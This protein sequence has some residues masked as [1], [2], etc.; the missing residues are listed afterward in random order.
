MALACTAV[1]TAQE[2]DVEQAAVELMQ[3]ARE[4]IDRGLRFLVERQREDGTFVSRNMGSNPAVVALGG[5]A[6]LASGSS[7]GRGPYGENI[8]R[9][10]DY[11]IRHTQ[12]S[13]FI[14]PPD[15]ASHGPMY[16]HGFATLYL[17]EV[18]GMSHRPDLR[19]KL[20]A[21]VDLIVK[22]QN[23][24]G[25]WRYQP[26]PDDADISVTICQI[27]A[28]R[29][30]R[31]A[32]IEVPNQTVDACIEYVRKCQNPDGGF[33]YMLNQ[34]SSMFPRSAAGIVALNSAGIYEG[35]E[36]ERGLAYL[37]QFPP[38]TTQINN[39]SH[40]FYGQYYASQAMWNAG[41]ERWQNWYT[42]IRDSLVNTQSPGGAWTDGVAPEYATAMAC[43]VLQLP[44]NAI[45]IFQR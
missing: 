35:P 11:L 18:Y 38:R 5:M 32:G 22:S 37:D 8:D 7:P 31:N 28:L 43:I 10:V 39:Q 16:G 33:S 24:E 29:A 1:A 41:G 4:S 23:R 40:Y 20:V 34:R 26:Q 42:G 13:G 19:Q 9:A 6:F 12:P 14:C 36:I 21:A 15:Q 25:G 17:A 3:P 2:T 27:M 44:N 45:P 30:A